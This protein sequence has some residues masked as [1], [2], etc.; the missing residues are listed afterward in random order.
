MMRSR[1]STEPC[2]VLLGTLEAGLPQPQVAN[3][4]AMTAATDGAANCPSAGRAAPVS[5]R[6]LG[7]FAALSPLGAS[8]W[9]FP[10]SSQR[11]ER[12]PRRTRGHLGVL[13]KPAAGR[14]LAT[15]APNISTE[16]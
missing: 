1:G 6:A 5:G 14:F 2:D 9:T 3:A 12:A 16:A 13:K 7:T 10:L 15:S 11:R 8:P 4:K